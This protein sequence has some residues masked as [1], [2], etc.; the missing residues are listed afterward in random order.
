[1]SKIKNYIQRGTSLLNIISKIQR[2]MANIEQN[3]NVKWK[4]EYSPDGCRNEQMSNCKVDQQMQN[5]ST[6][7]IVKEMYRDVEMGK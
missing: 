5:D 4:N 2:W 1:M 3:I 6:H 7:K